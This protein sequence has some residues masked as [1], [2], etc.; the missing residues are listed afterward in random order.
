[1]KTRQP[2]QHSDIVSGL[3]HWTSFGDLA[4][5]YAG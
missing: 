1:V 3:K 5:L 2:E 4:K